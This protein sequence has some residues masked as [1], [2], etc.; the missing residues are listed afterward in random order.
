VLFNNT[1][2]PKWLGKTALI[3]ENTNWGYSNHMTRIRFD[4]SKVESSWFALFLHKLFLDGYYQQIAKNHVNQS[5]INSTTLVT[6]VSIIMA[7]RNEQKRIIC[8]IEELFSKIDSAKQSL[9]YTKLQLKQYKSSLLKFAFEGKLTENWRGKNNDKI[10]EIQNDAHLPIGWTNIEFKKSINNI[11]LTGK[12]LKQKEYLQ[13]GKFPVIDQGQDFI[14]GFTN[15]GDFLVKCQLPVIIFGDH[16]KS[17][18]FV[19]QHFVAGA[20]GI[21][22]LQPKSFFI[23]KLLYYFIQAIPL[24]NKGYARH[25]QYLEKSNTKLPPRNEQKQIV[26]QIEQGFSLIEN[27]TQIINSVLQKLQ[28]M[29]ISILKQAFEGK[30]VPQDPNDESAEILLEKIKHEKEQLIQKQK[31][32]KVKKN[33]K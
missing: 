28:I 22:V 18:K 1:N 32:S 30:L 25:Y 5:S 10:K 8:K 6:K 13:T 29:K 2:S 3:K 20:D 7:P 27:T 9:E 33:V 23:P 14:G 4:T 19:N 17:I 26:F 16:T 21:K 12:K 24:P 31:V 15:K 11:P